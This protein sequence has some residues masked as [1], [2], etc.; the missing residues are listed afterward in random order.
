MA[1]PTTATEDRTFIDGGNIELISVI[2]TGAYGV[3]YLGID[4]KYGCPIYRA[5][6]CLQRNGLDP[7]QRHFQRREIALHGLASHHPS[8]VTMDRLIEEGEYLYVIMEYGD[9]GDLFGMIT[10]RQRVSCSTGNFPVWR[11]TDIYAVCGQQRTYQR[12][13]PP[14]VRRYRLATSAWYR[15]PRH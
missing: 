5:V 3:V 15:T 7:R 6:K 8:I 9:E 4:T 10:D 13:L 1:S 14:V 11:L 12:R 2:G